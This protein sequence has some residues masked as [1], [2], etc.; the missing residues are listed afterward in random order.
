MSPIVSLIVGLLS[1]THTALSQT[2]ATINPV[3]AATFASGYAGRV[4][5]NGLK[6][7]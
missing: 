6:G 5:V 1:M 4:V 7:M 2:C 3:N